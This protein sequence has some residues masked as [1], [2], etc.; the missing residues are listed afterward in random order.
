MEEIFTNGYN[1]VPEKEPVPIREQLLPQ[2]VEVHDQTELQSEYLHPQR[3]LRHKV[4]VFYEKFQNLFVETFSA[5]SI[6][7]NDKELP[8]GKDNANNITDFSQLIS[9]N[10]FVDE[11]DMREYHRLDGKK[12]LNGTAKLLTRTYGGGT[13][14]TVGWISRNVTDEKGEFK[15]Y[16]RLVYIFSANHSIVRWQ[17]RAP[18]NQIPARFRV[19]IYND[20]NTVLYDKLVENNKELY[21]LDVYKGLCKRIEL[22]VMKWGVVKENG[23]IVYEAGHSA[24]I[25]YFYHNTVFP[26]GPTDYHS[27]DFLQSFSVNEYLCS[28]IGKANYGVQSNTGQFSLVNFDRILD[29]F[30]YA[31]YLKNGLKVQFYVALDNS[32]TSAE[33]RD[34]DK[35]WVLLATQY[36]TDIEFDDVK[37]VVKF[38]TQDRL[39][40]FKDVT[41]S[42]YKKVAGGAL[43][44]IKNLDLVQD[45]MNRA[46]LVTEDQVYSDEIPSTVPVD[47]LP[48]PIDNNRLY[49]LTESAIKA[50]ESSEI[51]NAYL[52]GTSVWAA[53][54]NV[55]DTYLVH[56]YVDRADVLVVDR[57][58]QL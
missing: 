57:F 30:S 8:S 38:N 13:T 36:I 27:D 32:P 3:T 45:I 10:G 4:T 48:E 22:I 25:L 7:S 50:M 23:T 35:Q 1:A 16:P 11:V 21:S 5:D 49:S 54:Q 41:Y 9:K 53:L 24:Q 39:I 6:S 17:V 51:V 31:G 19:R 29:T 34:E 14:Q 26:E 2:N 44:P 37:N 18:K 47:A 43:L 42:G 12:P 58:D 28:S 46:E 15:E 33:N 55:C 40:G 56:I 52:N 20:A